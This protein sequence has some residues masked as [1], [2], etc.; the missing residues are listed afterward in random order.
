[1]G[2][3]EGENVTQFLQINNFLV[4]VAIGT[5][6]IFKPIVTITV[7]IGEDV[8]VFVTSNVFIFFFVLQIR[9]YFR[10]ISAAYRSRYPSIFPRVSAGK[11]VSKQFFT[12]SFWKLTWVPGLAFLNRQINSSKYSL[13]RSPC[14]QRLVANCDYIL[15]RDD[16]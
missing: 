5:S 7:F 16:R 13:I 14:L 3:G 2:E 6:F 12:S 1:M 10:A 11:P 8:V 15:I 4:L 9:S